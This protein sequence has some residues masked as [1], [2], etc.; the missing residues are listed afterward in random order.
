[1]VRRSSATRVGCE[2]HGSVLLSTLGT[3]DDGAMTSP[4]M[5]AARGGHLGAVR[6]R[7]LTGPFRYS[8]DAQESAELLDLIKPTT[9]IPVHYEGWTH[10]AEDRPQAEPKLAASSAA[11]SMHWLDPGQSVTVDV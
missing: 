6:F 2:Y 1:M 9:T 5:F 8:M 10:F 7:Y 3:N 11:G 4:L